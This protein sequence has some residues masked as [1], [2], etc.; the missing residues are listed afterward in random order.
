MANT[1]RESAALA[2]TPACFGRL[3]A[4]RRQSLGL[5]QEDLSQRL[6]LGRCMIGAIERGQRGA[7]MMIVLRLLY[8]LDIDLKDLVT[9]SKLSIDQ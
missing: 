1:L 8:L 5:S 7:S 4:I 9:A 2:I 6:G 3:V